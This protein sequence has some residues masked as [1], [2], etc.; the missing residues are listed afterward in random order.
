M[1]DQFQV[2]DYGALDYKKLN[3]NLLYLD[4]INNNYDFKEVTISPDIV[5]RYQGN[6][7]GLLR[8]TG[9]VDPHL[10]IYTMYLNGIINPVDFNFNGVLTIKIPIKPP[11]PAD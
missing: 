5:Y 10:Y 7:I 1:L 11:I 4:H 9:V 2:N 6:F 8:R 3:D